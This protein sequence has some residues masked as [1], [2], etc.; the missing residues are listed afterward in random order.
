MLNTQDFL[1]C[2]VI[3]ISV[4]YGLLMLVDFIYGLFHLQ[5]SR[6]VTQA[7]T[8]ATVDAITPN[9]VVNTPS[10]KVE[11]PQLPLEAST[12]VSTP[13]NDVDAT[14]AP[15]QPVEAIKPLPYI[16]IAS[17]RLYKMKGHS[18]VSIDQIPF[19]I[20]GH[21]KQYTLKKHKVVKLTDLEVLINNH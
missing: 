1:T 2:S 6:A 7:A 21:I 20:P 16:D 5:P 13:Q 11:S 14:E 15:N 12:T 4:A 18:M 9:P 10:T 3:A 17:L 19:T 8:E